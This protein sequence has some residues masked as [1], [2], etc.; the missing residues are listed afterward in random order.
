[1]IAGTVNVDFEAIITISLCS[2]SGTVYTQDA[3]IDTGFNGWLSLPPDLIAKL[4]LRW[5]R[6][7]RAILGDG[8]ECIFNVYEAIVIWDGSY[9]TIPIDEADSEPL[10]GMSLMEGYQLMVQVFEGGNVE[11]QK[12]RS[13]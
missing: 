2:S 4:N 13:V 1:M 9:L 12:V 6:R 5:K 7:G 8:S 10:V 3:I 11:I